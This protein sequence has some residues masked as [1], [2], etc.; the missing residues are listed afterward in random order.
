M[1][2]AH[3]LDA[4]SRL[5]PKSAAIALRLL[6]RIASR[7]DPRARDGLH[8]ML[9]DQSRRS[10]PFSDSDLMALITHDTPVVER[11]FVFETAH[12]RMARLWIQSVMADASLRDGP[13]RPRPDQEAAASSAELNVALGRM[14]A[15]VLAGSGR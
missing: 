3:H 13:R 7:L 9:A 6:A 2:L 14:T 5:S 12:Q 8:D 4:A 10:E 11:V 15:A 1:D